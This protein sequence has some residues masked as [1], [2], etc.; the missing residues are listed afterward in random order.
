MTEFWKRVEELLVPENKTQLW[1]AQETEI[2]QTTLSGWKLNDRIPPADKAYRIAQVLQVSLDYLV[3][4]ERVSWSRDQEGMHTIVPDEL[5]PDQQ[6]TIQPPGKFI[7]PTNK[8][9]R[10]KNKQNIIMIPVLEQ[11]VSAGPGEEGIEE[12][13]P[14]RFLPVLEDLVARYDKRKLRVVKVKGDSMTG[15]Q[16]FHGDLAIFAADKIE[17]DGIYVISIHGEAYVKRLEFDPFE[18]SVVVHSENKNYA[19]KVIPAK[20]E[21]MTIEGKVVGWFHNHPY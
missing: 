12:Y 11:K 13:T 9:I 18:G 7:T 3:S 6:E 16:L 21:L 2:K 8:I 5:D 17:G 1:L 10:L 14:E 20:S 4:G 19:P 15:V